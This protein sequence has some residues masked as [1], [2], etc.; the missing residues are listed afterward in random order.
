MQQVLEEVDKW[1]VSGIYLVCEHPNGDY[2]ISDPTWLANVLD[3][4]GGS[5]ISGKKVVL[6]YCNH[7]MLIAASTSANAIASGT[8]MNVRSFPPT[9][10][11]NSY[12]DEIKQR[13]TWY[14]CPDAPLSEYKI[15]FLD[16]PQQQGVLDQM[17]VP[18]ALS[19]YADN[20]FSGP[21]P[22]T[23]PFSEQHAF[24]HYLECLRHQTLNAR[25]DT[26]DATLEFHEQ[27]LDSAENLLSRFHAV[28]IRGQM[29][30]F[31][32]FSM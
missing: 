20:L 8:W 23:V 16:I 1:D 14:Y 22:T 2:F 5:R 32:K 25:H 10:F 11:R 9:K 18:A 7:Q 12:E 4:V 3:L 21:Q 30:D 17:R 24:R 29:R 31:E 19:P 6:G 15:A 27:L 28:G 26:F 13:T